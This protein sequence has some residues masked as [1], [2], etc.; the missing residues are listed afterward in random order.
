[1]S[2]T[3]RPYQQ[4]AVDAAIRWMKKNSEPA[5][6]ELS[7]GA[8]KSLICAEIARVM[9][10]L[11]GKRILVL[12]PNQDLL[13]KN[14]EKMAMTGEKFSYYSAS[15]S[16]SLRH[17]IVLATEGTFKSIAKKIGHEFSC[18]VVDEAHRVTPTFKQIITDMREGNPNLRVIGMT[19]TPFR[20]TEGYIYDL[21]LENK[22][23]QEATNPYYKKLLYRVT[24]D[25]LI[26]QGYLTPAQIGLPSESY[27][28]SKI[29]L[30]DREDFTES[31]LKKTFE[32][33]SVTSK[34]VADMLEKTKHH[35]G[36]IVFC[37][38]L[39]HAHFESGLAMEHTV[40]ILCS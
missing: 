5:L 3:L 18:V 23:M 21:D 34:I 27:D 6:L 17:H 12:V 14:G 7:G 36:V 11:S 24:C 16:K 37:A 13:L 39:K 28:T 32:L 15:V 22:I 4:A 40:Q 9:Y 8:G 35:L 20:T 25:D 33:K 2:Y 1:M 38:T 30:G 10:Q 19:G 29:V 31:E 26:A